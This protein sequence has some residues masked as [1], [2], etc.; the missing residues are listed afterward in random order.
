MRH[1]LIRADAYAAIGTGHVMRCLALAQAWQDMSGEVAFLAHEFLADG[2]KKRLKD[3]GFTVIA[4]SHDIGSEQDANFTVETARNY[5]SFLVLDGYKFDANYQK[6]IFS[7]EI[8]SLVI[9]DYGHAD[10]YYADFILNQNSYAD[11][12]TYRNRQS[13][14]Q[15]L[16][17]SD[18]ALL[19]REF[20]NW[21]DWQRE[22]PPKAQKLLVTLGGSDPD[23][24]TLTVLQVLQQLPISLE[25]TVIV[26]ASN[27]HYDDLQRYV[28]EHQLK[29]TL[30]RNVVDMPDRMAQ[31]DIAIAAGGST[32]WE[33]CLLGLPTAIIVI[34]DNQRE[35]A[36]DLH[37]RNIAVNLGW[38][39]NLKPEQVQAVLERLID[40]ESTR[41]QMAANGSKLVDGYGAKRAAKILFRED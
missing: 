26:G 36:T 28:A 29:V 14:T 40:D 34:A 5:E 37:D 3:E 35:I 32:N 21:R 6:I 16:V 10:V 7:A 8:S 17:G 38:H 31:A 23:N 4:H 1:L 19:R 24:L 13:N 12:D 39:E 20:W 18:Y 41:K 30:A 33:M 11:P 15:L 9:D 27:P 2:L 22:I 25:I